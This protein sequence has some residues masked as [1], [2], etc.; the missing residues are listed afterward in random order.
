M[1]RFGCYW[2]TA[3][4]R[5]HLSGMARACSANHILLPESM[6]CHADVPALAGIIATSPSPPQ[7]AVNVTAQSAAIPSALSSHAFCIQRLQL[8]RTLIS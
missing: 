4:A 2:S 5:G 6:T 3:V 1:R 7:P 8:S